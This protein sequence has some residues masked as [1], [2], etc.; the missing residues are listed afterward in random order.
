M[1]ACLYTKILKHLISYFVPTSH[2]ELSEPF[3]LSAPLNISFDI[4]AAELKTLV[5][6]NQSRWSELVRA[7]NTSSWEGVRV[8]VTSKMMG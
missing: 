1:D 5:P 3:N 2:E 7:F 6:V 4:I 8:L